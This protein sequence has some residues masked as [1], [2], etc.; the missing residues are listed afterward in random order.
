M[1]AFNT[2][3]L[4]GWRTDV[5]HIDELFWRQEAKV[6]C[7]KETLIFG[8]NSCAQN[9]TQQQTLRSGN[10]ENEYCCEY[11]VFIPIQH[12]WWYKT[13]TGE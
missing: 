9:K 6:C 12:P 7:D 2:C 13:T 8:T 5:K 11:S 1:L 3:H 10:R 4:P